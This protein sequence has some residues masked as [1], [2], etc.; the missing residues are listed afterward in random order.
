MTCALILLQLAGYFICK[1]E[2][3]AQQSYAPF[4]TSAWSVSK[5][6]IGC[7]HDGVA[8]GSVRWVLS[9]VPAVNMAV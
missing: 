1:G 2:P 6:P 3:G 8:I 9:G 4:G 7:T 5:L